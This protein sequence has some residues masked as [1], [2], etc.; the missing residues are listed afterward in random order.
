MERLQ[1]IKGAKAPNFTLNKRSGME[2]SCYN[3]KFF[4]SGFILTLVWLN[5]WNTPITCY[6]FQSFLTSIIINIFFCRPSNLKL[7]FREVYFQW[8]SINDVPSYGGEGGGLEDGDGKFQMF[9]DEGG[10]RNVSLGTSLPYDDFQ[11]STIVE[12][13]DNDNDV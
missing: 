6:Q 10:G 4:S 13:D 12:A 11:N 1:N 9:R 3:K 8:P 5:V 2:H 7:F